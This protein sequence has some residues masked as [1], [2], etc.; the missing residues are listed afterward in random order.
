MVNKIIN[1]EEDKKANF[2]HVISSLRTNGYQSWMFKTTGKEERQQTKE[3]KQCQDR[4]TEYWPPIHRGTVREIH[5]TIAIKW[6]ADVP[7][8][9]EHSKIVACAS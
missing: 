9:P 1:E 3:H 8:A 5:T 7:Q 2:T 4:N 6:N